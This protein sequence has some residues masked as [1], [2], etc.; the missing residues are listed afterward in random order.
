M[1][2]FLN[3]TAGIGVL[4]QASAISQEMFPGRVTTVA[5]AGFV[6]LMSLFNMGGRFFWSSVFGL[7][8]SPKHLLH[9]LQLRRGALRSRAEDRR[10]G[11]RHVVRHCVR[12]D[13]Q[14][15]R[16][17]ICHH[18][19]L[20]ER[21]VRHEIRRSDSRN[22][23]HGLGLRAG[24]ASTVL[25]NYIREYNVNHGVAK[26]QAYNTTMYVM[27]ALLVVGFICDLIVPPR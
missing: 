3:V 5:A 7:S 16:R 2:L 10:N 15:V 9:L 1:I 27:A 20:F 6:G 19:G 8:G 24:I 11:Q 14:Y 18:T 25:V 22:V 26:A 21:H 13:I 4:G 23:A 17:G 12:I